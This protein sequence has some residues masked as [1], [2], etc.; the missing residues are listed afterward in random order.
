MKKIFL[1]IVAISLT[2]G[3]KAQE[4]DEFQT[5]FGGEPLQITGFGGPF[6]NFSILDGNFAHLMGGG[7]GVLINDFF[8]GGYG[9]GLTNSIPYQETGNE[10]GFAHGGFWLGYNFMSNRI[11]HPVL[12][13]QLGWGEISEREPAGE[14]VRSGDNIFVVNPTLE[15][16]MNVTNYFKI[17]AGGNYRLV[18]FIDEE[19]YSDKDFMNPGVFLSFKFGWFN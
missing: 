8:F 15:L 9:L 12:H 6:M 19:G 14:K 18:T 3:L 16:E 4:E 10:L 5:L 13:L 1:L 17:A 7:G 2:A 11:I